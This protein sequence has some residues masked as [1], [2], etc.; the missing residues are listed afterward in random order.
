M[1]MALLPTPCRA[2]D[3]ISV[4]S[5]LH[6]EDVN[7]RASLQHL[8]CRTAKQLL[9]ALTLQACLHISS[10][11]V[12]ADKFS[13]KPCTRTPVLVM[14]YCCHN[15]HNPYCA[16]NLRGWG[17]NK[18]VRTRRRAAALQPLWRQSPCCSG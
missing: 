14:S 6:P 13:S 12:S 11:R 18:F 17:E 10:C 7:C 1:R 9:T 15:S 3:A 2:A 16:C 8:Q 4:A 5:Q